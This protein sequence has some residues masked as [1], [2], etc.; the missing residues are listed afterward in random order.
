MDAAGASTQV[1]KALP[2]EAPTFFQPQQQ[3]Q[4]PAASLCHFMAKSLNFK[5]I[6]RISVLGK[7]IPEALTR[8]GVQNQRS[9][10]WWGRLHTTKTFQPKLTANQFI[11]YLKLLTQ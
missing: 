8:T 7:N 2:W 4:S 10:S 11:F 9:E 1:P 6:F 5:D 3:K